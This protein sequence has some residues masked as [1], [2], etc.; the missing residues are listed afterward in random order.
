MPSQIYALALI[1]LAALPSFGYKADLENK[2]AQ[3]LI[4]PPKAA[5]VQAVKATD[6]VI[7]LK[8]DPMADA[9]ANSKAAYFMDYN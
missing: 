4:G 7:P 9:M 3:A 1:L 2:L 8:T 5:T 6:P